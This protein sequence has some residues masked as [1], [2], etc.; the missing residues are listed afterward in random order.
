M[1]YKECLNVNGDM[2]IGGA[3]IKGLMSGNGITAF[4]ERCLLR[5]CSQS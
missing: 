5:G 3:T 2:R 1:N 4:V